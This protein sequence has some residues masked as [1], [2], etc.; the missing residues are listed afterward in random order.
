MLLAL[1]D[2]VGPTRMFQ[3]AHSLDMTKDAIEMWKKTRVWMST[4]TSQD[5]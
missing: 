4:V 1:S 2:E 5:V 3:P